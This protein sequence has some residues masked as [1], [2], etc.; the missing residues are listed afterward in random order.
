MTYR[1]LIEYDGAPYCG[2]QRQKG[3]PS[4][5]AALEEALAIVLRKPTPLVG[6]GRTDS[7]VHARGQVAHFRTEA[8]L[9]ERRVARA[10][11]GLTP[12]SIAVHGLSIAPDNFHARYD[13]ISRRYH[14]YVSVKPSALGRGYRYDLPYA[15][16]F[17]AM[18]EAAACFLGEHDFTS[19]C[20]HRSAAVN[21][22]CVVTCAR[23][24]QGGR[25]QHWTFAV[26]ANRFLHGMVRAMV[27]TL[28]DI[29]RGKQPAAHLY[30]VLAS[31]DR[32]AAGP[33][34]PPHGLVLEC[35]EY[36]AH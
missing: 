6:A 31:R 18:N 16:D 24:T 13:A 14:Y 17:D 34:A 35:I 30:S 5:Q 32:R 26:V 22:I 10:L 21:K 15:V 3:L 12:A 25:P 20:L 27:G 9:D 36:A 11:N 2:W 1:L 23:W 29:G 33:A 4:V 8:P 19:F 7:G 28:I